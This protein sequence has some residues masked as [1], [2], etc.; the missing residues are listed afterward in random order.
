MHHL[1]H[2]PVEHDDEGTVQPPLGLSVPHLLQAHGEDDNIH[3]NVLK[4]STLTATSDQP[5]VNDLQMVLRDK[6][7][8][9]TENSKDQVD[10]LMADIPA[11]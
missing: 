11:L 2:R 10:E 1:P 8:L 6:G 4:N 9:D 5:H 3:E 7:I